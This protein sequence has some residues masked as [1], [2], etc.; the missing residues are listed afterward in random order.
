[1]SEHVVNL[2]DHFTWGH[3]ES[4]AGWLVAQ[5]VVLSLGLC[6]EKGGQLQGCGGSEA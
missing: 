6:K 1:M 3:A 4:V 5:K 2:F